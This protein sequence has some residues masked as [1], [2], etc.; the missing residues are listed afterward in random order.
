LAQDLLSS[1]QPDDLNEL[2]Q[3]QYVMLLEEQAYPFE[4]QAIALHQ[5][6]LQLGWQVSWDDAI[7]SSLLALQD[8]SPGRFRRDDAEVTYVQSSD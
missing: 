5:R 7:N 3:D 2:E 1:E 6:N 8:L 4:E